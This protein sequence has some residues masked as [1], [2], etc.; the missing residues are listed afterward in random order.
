[1]QHKVGAYIRVSTEE[2]AQVIEGS[3][4]SQRHRLNA[5]VELKN[6]QESGRWGKVI[7]IYA[8]EGFSAKDTRRPALQKLLGDLRTG[9]V[10]LILVTDLSRLSR[11][12]LD[13]CLL[14]DDLRKHG[15]KFLSVKEQFDTTTAAGHMMVMNMIN[16]AQFEREQVAE[17]VAQNFFSRAQRGLL[18][19]GPVILGYDKNPD[20]RSEYIV[21]DKEAPLVRDIFRFFLEEGT[22]SRTIRRLNESAI[23][24]KLGIDREFRLA[25]EGAWTTDGLRRLL[26]NKAYIGV[27]EV[28]KKYR[29]RES[30]SLLPWQKHQETKAAW[31][32]IVPEE[33]FEKVH[34]VLQSGRK[35]ERPKAH[36]VTGSPFILTG[37]L[38]C[39]DCGAPFVGETGHGRTT[40]VRYYGHKQYQGIPFRCPVRRF[41]AEPAEEAVEKHLAE[42]ALN[43]K[44]LERVELAISDDVDLEVAD[45]R[46]DKERLQIRLLEIDKESHGIFRALSDLSDQ[47]GVSLVKEK[48]SALGS[49]K[50]AITG[51]LLEIED[52]LQESG[53]KKLAVERIGARVLEFKAGWRKGSLSQK[54]DHATRLHRLGSKFT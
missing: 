17:R 40:S 11:N 41:P 21:N 47:G 15:G 29:T 20:R 14:L 9:K 10:N 1:M 39:A 6:M 44:G 23:P 26:E 46:K 43:P 37:R 38:C 35:L 4:D 27:R 51:R 34:R 22:L 54:N 13:F 28:N 8:D 5:F 2:Q 53:R 50:T 36:H 24:R 25:S 3:L 49:E 33:T 16:L 32:G 7:D 12:I 30:Q 31:P 18:N 19:G 52:R 45:V 48:I 42:I